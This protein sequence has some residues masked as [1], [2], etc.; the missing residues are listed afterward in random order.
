NPLIVRSTETGEQMAKGGDFF[1]PKGEPSPAKAI[2]APDAM[3]REGAGVKG[4]ETTGFA[5]LDFLADSSA[6]LVNLIP[7]KNGVVKLSRK[8]LGP[9]AMIHVVAVDPASTTYR[10]IT[11]PEQKASFVDLRLRN[12]LDP[13]A[14]FT[15]QKQ[16]SVLESGKPF[17]LADA[18]GAHFEV[19][20]SLPKVYALYSTLS[21]DPKLAEFAFI[22]T[23]PKLKPEEKRALYSKFACHELNFFLLKK[24]PDFFHNVIRP[25]LANKKDKT[26]LDHWFLGDDLREFLQP[27]QYGRLNAVE[28]VLLAQRLAGEPAKTSR[29]EQDLLR[30]QPPNMDRFLILFDTSV[31]GSALSK[32]G[33][34]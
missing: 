6:V 29:H 12:G 21:K 28:R 11:L 17:V 14:H 18:A 3:L 16:I 24:D 31:K 15:Q 26:F 23:W 4:A 20:D 34:E 32:V 22:L 19:Y 5:N 30:L 10:S 7:D 8:D 33:V 27:W 9:H 13:K 1:A 25:F 2:P